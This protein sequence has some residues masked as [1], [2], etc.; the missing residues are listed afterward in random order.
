MPIAQELLE[1]LACPKC[2]A[3]VTLKDDGSGFVCETC[4]LVYPIV[5]DIPNF[6]IDEALPLDR[7]P[8]R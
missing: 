1:I 2:K 6:L 8:R 3:K 4:R 7:E 5:D